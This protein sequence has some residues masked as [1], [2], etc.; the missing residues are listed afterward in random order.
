MNDLD[1][2]RAALRQPPDEPFAEP[3]LAAIMAGGTRLRRRRR[4]LTSAAGIAAAAVVVLVVGF[5]I[6]VRQ[7][8]PAPVAQPPAPV[9]TTPTPAPSTA[10]EQPVGDVIGTGIKTARG[11]I[12]FFARA[13]DLPELPDTHFGLVAGFRSGETLESVLMTNEFRGSD[14]SFGFHATDGG[15]LSGDEVIPVFG[16]FAGQVARITTTVHGKTVDANLAKWTA[17]PNVV[18]FWFDPAAVPNSAVLT[19]LIAYDAAGK[20]L[21]K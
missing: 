10:A 15:E 14:R 12:V 8:A 17:D 21:T 7:P 1:D 2:F 6:Q 9:V 3:D 20:R 19:P 18:I 16:Y 4:V 5:A 11:E 13:V